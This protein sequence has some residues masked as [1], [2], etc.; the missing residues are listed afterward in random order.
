[1][2]VMSFAEAT[3]KFL[4]TIK[5]YQ[6]LPSSEKSEASHMLL[7]YEAIMKDES[8]RL[9]IADLPL[10]LR[11]TET[12]QAIKIKGIELADILFRRTI[13]FAASNELVIAN[14]SEFL[15]IHGWDLE[16]IQ[17]KA[18][19]KQ[20][21][22]AEIQEFI[23]RMTTFIAGIPVNQ[24]S[25]PAALLAFNRGTLPSAFTY[26][27]G[28]Y[29]NWLHHELNNNSFFHKTDKSKAAELNNKMKLF[30]PCIDECDLEVLH[31]FTVNG[32][33]EYV[34]DHQT[35]FALFE[36]NL[37]LEPDNILAEN[38]FY[39]MLFNLKSKRRNA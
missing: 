38:R 5:N 39:K 28:Q 37:A 19:L 21:K 14:Y 25:E 10:L 13:E 6:A 32:M 31:E 8:P 20:K 29:L 15:N 24:S 4:E 7:A 35:A 11:L 26:A 22:F 27:A 3:T 17:I 1:M 23:S 34:Y 36:K 33:A 30:I 12:N 9:C 18:Y 2:F 16:S